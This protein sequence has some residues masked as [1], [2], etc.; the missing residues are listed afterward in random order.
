MIKASLI[1]ILGLVACAAAT[2]T[3]EIT[4]MHFFKAGFLSSPLTLAKSM[5][6][7]SL[8]DNIVWGTC[9]SE[10]EFKVDYSNTYNKPQPPS[11]G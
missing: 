10:G 8:K 5:V 1:A 6:R 9:P 2:D 7:P 3:I 4:P 11:K